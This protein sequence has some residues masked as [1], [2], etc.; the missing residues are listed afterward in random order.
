MDIKYFQPE[1]MD[2]LREE[3]IKL[4]ELTKK[5][6]KELE[7]ME[8][9]VMK[10]ED[11]QKELGCEGDIKLFGRVKKFICGTGISVKIG[12][13]KDGNRLFV[14]YDQKKCCLPKFLDE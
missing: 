6:L 8:K 14:F 7:K 13:S 4:E 3:K 9:V 12:R 10:E 1:D 2:P 5:V 11:I